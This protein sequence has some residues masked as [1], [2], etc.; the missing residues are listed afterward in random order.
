MFEVLRNKQIIFVFSFLLIIG[1]AVTFSQ[2]YSPSSPISHDNKTGITISGKQFTTGSDGVSIL[3]KNCKDITISDCR[4]ILNSGIIGIQMHNCS[5]ITVKN[6]YFES[7]RTG[8][9]AISCSGGIDIQCNEF[10]NIAGASPRGQIVQFNKCSGA[11]NRVNYNILDHEFGT[12]NPEDLINMYGS[13]GTSS[14]PIQII[15]NKLRGGGPSKSGGGIMVGDDG[16]HDIRVEDN[17]LVDV[18]QY[19]IGCPAG[20][21]ITIRNNKI[22]GKQQSFTNVGLY[23]GLQGEIDAGFSCNGPS[24]RVE[25]NQINWKNKNG[26]QNDYYN[27]PCCPGVVTVNNTWRA[28]I[29]PEILPSVL[30]PDEHCGSGSTAVKSPVRSQLTE[31]IMP[32]LKFTRRNGDEIIFT[33]NLSRKE[34]FKLSVFDLSGRQV[35]SSRQ[36]FSGAG[37]HRVIWHP[38]KGLSEQIRTVVVRLS[39]GEDN[40]YRKIVLN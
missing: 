7:F 17:I 25:S 28:P 19:G 26:V 27:C 16:G 18:G 3:L 23:A 24:I 13:S 4:F 40:I 35:F 9:Y 11:G 8:I 14:D 29:G 31:K 12:G 30:I 6:C 22:Y 15:G 37:T 1:S 21:N 34:S 38:S 33:I 5:N 10:R 39:S 32:D 36:S 20:Y 2:A